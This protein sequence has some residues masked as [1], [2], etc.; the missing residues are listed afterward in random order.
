MLAIALLVLC[1]ALYTAYNSP[2]SFRLRE[3]QLTSN[4]L[5]IVL[6]LVTMAGFFVT[7]IAKEIVAIQT[8]GVLQVQQAMQDMTDRQSNRCDR[9]TD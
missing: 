9:V 1:V 2:R 7:L 3:V 8:I 5:T 6:A 4:K